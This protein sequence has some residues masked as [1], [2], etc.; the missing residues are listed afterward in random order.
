MAKKIAIMVTDGNEDIEVITPADIWRRAGIEVELISIDS[1]VD[2]NLAHGTKIKADKLQFNT[3]I[4][5]YDAV[6]FPGGPGYTN[7]AKAFSKNGDFINTLRDKFNETNDKFILALCAAP[8][9]LAQVDLI[10]YRNATCYRGFEKRFKDTYQH[11]PVCS[12]QHLI[13]GAS[14]FY[15]AD[16]AIMVVKEMLPGKINKLE[17]E[18]LVNEYQNENEE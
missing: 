18:L 16:F 3:N 7:Y 8:D 15:A 12:H 14:C 13:T 2:I 17:D 9:F 6:Y 4:N 5:D 1:K 10:N 11:V